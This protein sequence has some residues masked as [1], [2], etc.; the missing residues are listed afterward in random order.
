MEGLARV[1][2]LR[3][4]EYAFA[5]VLLK[6]PSG[7]LDSWEGIFRVAVT[8]INARGPAMLTLLPCKE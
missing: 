5:M 6:L 3:E 7:H 1:C 4:R 2:R 8:S